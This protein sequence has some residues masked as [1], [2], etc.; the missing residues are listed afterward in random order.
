MRYLVLLFALNLFAIDIID[1]PIVFDKERIDLTKEYIHEHYGLEVDNINITPRIIVIHWTS[2]NDFD[3]SLKR[4]TDTRLPS[5]RPDIQKASALNVSAHFLVKRDGTIYRLMDETK[6]AR[7]VIGL[8]YSSIGI[9]NVGGTNSIN[10]LTQAQLKANIE[11]ILYLKNKYKSISY[12]IG[13]HEYKDFSEHEL[14]L[15]K[16]KSYRTVKHDPSDEFMDKLHIH[17]PSLKRTPQ[18]KI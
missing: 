1:K 4:F 18:E 7:H 15:E 11:L 5:D 16:D 2:I 3:S 17:F 13:H 9:E 10:D 8:N 12:L 14:W 6:M